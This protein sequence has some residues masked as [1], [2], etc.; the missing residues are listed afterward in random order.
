MPLPIMAATSLAESTTES[1]ELGRFSR[2]IFVWL[3]DKAFGVGAPTAVSAT[4]GSL[5]ERGPNQ[6]APVC[7]ICSRY[8]QAASAATRTVARQPSRTRPLRQPFTVSHVIH[9]TTGL[10]RALHQVHRLDD[11][12]LREL[13]GAERRLQS[14]EIARPGFPAR[15]TESQVRTERAPAGGAAWRLECRLGSVLEDF[16]PRLCSAA[17]REHAPVRGVGE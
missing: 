11:Q 13:Q 9:R 5:V 4:G 12:R 7:R 8:H 6:R 15:A 17:Y 16:E 1:G 2:S 3:L 10:E 14:R